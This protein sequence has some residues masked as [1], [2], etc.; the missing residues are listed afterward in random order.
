M[1]VD[2]TIFGG[3]VAGLWAL[4]HLS[5]K[6]YE[7]AL[8]EKTS[9]GDGQTIRS[10]GIIHGGVKYS[11]SGDLRAD[12]VEEVKQMPSRWRAHLSGQRKDPDLS[13][14]KVNSQDY[15]LW[16]S[17]GRG[18]LGMAESF[19]SPVG[20]KLMNTPPKEVKGNA[21]PKSLQGNSSKVFLVDEPVV[22][23]YSL[24]EQLAKPYAHR[25][26]Y[27]DAIFED[28]DVLVGGKRIKSDY[29]VLT[30]G[31]GNQDLAG[32]LGIEEVVM[33]RRPL[34]QVTVSGNL[35]S[36][37]AHCIDGGVPSVSITS[38]YHR[39][40]DIVTWNIGGKVAEEGF[41][42]GREELIRKTRAKLEG[43]LPNTDFSDAKWDTFDIDRAE[44][45]TVDGKRP[46]TA[47]VR[48]IG[49]VLVCYPTKLALA[50]ILAEKIEKEL[51]LTKVSGSVQS[52]EGSNT[53]V[54]RAPWE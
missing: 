54:A 26:F 20:L 2:V 18:L 50:P 44:G 30:A 10:Q 25:I 34:R 29:F 15:F 12:S 23:T 42:I 51:N 32:K 48:R 8:I 47:N 9:L 31:N 36:L 4:N 45:V 14:V 22:E 17:G 3:G 37:F 39:E 49:N 33:Q 46:A 38:H 43:L 11:L 13:G 5:K 40:S 7:C 27:G 53:Q 35:P 52:N 19:L 41:K 28:G 21:I 1:N 16:V 6:G 24:L